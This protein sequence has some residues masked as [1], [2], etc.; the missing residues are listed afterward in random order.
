MRVPILTYHSQKIHGND[1]ANNDLVAFAADLAEIDRAGF[2]ILPLHDIVSRWL[3]GD[4]GLEGERVVAL[5]CDDGTDFDARDLPHPKAGMQRGLLGILQDFRDANPRRQPGLF[6]TSF[7]IVSPEA[8]LILDRTCMIGTR[9]WNDDWWQ[10]AIDSGLMGIA[11]HSWDHNH[12][13]LPEGDLAGVRRGTFETIDDERSADYEIAQASAYLARLKDNPAA[14]IFAYPYGETNEFLV[15]DY[16]PRRAGELGL[17]AAVGGDPRPFTADCGRWEI[18]RYFFE[19][20]WDT[21]E[22]LRRILDDA[23]R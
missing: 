20:D 14:S 3:R 7:V 6:A 17:V 15:R 16:L 13:T 5:T 22:G 9:W 1:Y 4:A 8:R 10:G 12:H 11:S 21:P 19:R 18:P 23:A 2:R